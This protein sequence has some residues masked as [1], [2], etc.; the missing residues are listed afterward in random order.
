MTRTISQRITIFHHFTMPVR[1]LQLAERF[2][3]EVL[4]A[5]VTRRLG[6]HISVVLGTGPRIDL[7]QQDEIEPAESGHPHFAWDMPPEDFLECT[8]ILAAH[9]VGYD[10]PVQQGP[11]GTASIYVDD[12]D[13]NH[14]ELVC[15]GDLKDMPLNKQRNRAGMRYDW[16]KS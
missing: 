7:F 6:N 4:G 12:P 8:E 5:E 13:G 15:R 16:P 10:G 11:P 9:G 3:T 14:L 2:Y 1:D